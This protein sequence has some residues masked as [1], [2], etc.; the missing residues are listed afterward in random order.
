MCTLPGNQTTIKSNTCIWSFLNITFCWFYRYFNCSILCKIFLF[1]DL[2]N[3][4][5]GMTT[6]QEYNIR[7]VWLKVPAQLKMSK[8]DTLYFDK[9]TA[10]KLY[11]WILLNLSFPYVDNILTMF[12]ICN[13]APGNSKL[14]SMSSIKWPYLRGKQTRH[15]AASALLA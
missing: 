1:L 13:F 15:A 7:L 10:L 12:N 8:N 2:V 14:L 6:M 11:I 3:I 4:C 9:A 5:G